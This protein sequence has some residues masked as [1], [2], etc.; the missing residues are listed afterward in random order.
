MISS[1]RVY[2]GAG[3]PAVIRKRDKSLTAKANA[4]KPATHRVVTT[5]GNTL[6]GIGFEAE[7]FAQFV[8]S[9]PYIG[10]NL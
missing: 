5:Y 10:R 1:E 7:L 3:R 8:L 2:R 4:T 6:E 9:R